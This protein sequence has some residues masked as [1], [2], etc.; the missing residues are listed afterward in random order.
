[1]I[2]RTINAGLVHKY[3]DGPVYGK[4]ELAEPSEGQ[5]QVKVLASGLH[6][7]VRGRA[8]GKHY[9]SPKVLPMIP[10][11]DGVGRLHDGSL[12]YFQGI[13]AKTGAFAEY[14]NVDKKDCFVLPSNADPVVVAALVNPTMAPWIALVGRAHIKKGAS[15]LILGVTGLSGQI[16]VQV[17]RV[18][19]ASRV[20]GIGRSQEKLNALLKSGL[21]AAITLTDDEGS[22]AAAIA[23]EAA[24]VDIVLDFLW[25]P[26]AKLVLQTIVEKRSHSDHLLEWVQIGQL[27]GATFELRADILRSTNVIIT[28]TGFGPLSDDETRKHIADLLAELTSG[29][30]KY[31][32]VEKTHLRDLEKT[33]TKKTDNRIVVCPWDEM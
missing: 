10:G 23:K 6:Q 13:R 32:G 18:L 11:V 21:D 25:G 9:S 16:G 4:I 24:N 12:V 8:S 19:G 7:L 1:M 31:D 22:T 2:S 5:V 17:A 30:L 15:V 27:A 3:G 14:I 20:I 26:P 29:K 33:W 28:G